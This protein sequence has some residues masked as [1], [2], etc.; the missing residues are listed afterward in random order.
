VGDSGINVAQ[1]FLLNVH[2]VQEDTVGD[3]NELDNHFISLLVHLI[4]FQPNELHHEKVI[5]LVI[6]VSLA[7]ILGK[8][9]KY[10]VNGF[11]PS[12]LALESENFA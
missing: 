10:L 8:R 4:V 3:V 9:F 12:K 2:L 6:L 7:V 1:V 5:A 11:V